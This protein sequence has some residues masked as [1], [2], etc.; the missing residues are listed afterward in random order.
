MDNQHS[1]KGED[2]IYLFQM[3][4]S[5]TRADG[6]IILLVVSEGKLLLNGLGLI[7]TW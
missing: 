2:T 4:S 3:N 5:N 7:K 1:R 6:W